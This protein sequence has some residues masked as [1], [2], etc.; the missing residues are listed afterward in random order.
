MLPLCPHDT[1]TRQG[2]WRKQKRLLWPGISIIW[3][4]TLLY[5]QQPLTVSFSYFLSYLLR[6]L[7]W[8]PLGP[9]DTVPPEFRTHPKA[10]YSTCCLHAHMVASTFR[11]WR[12]LTCNW[13]RPRS[14]ITCNWTLWHRR[15]PRHQGM[16]TNM[17]FG[18]YTIKLMVSL[19]QV[20]RRKG[21]TWQM[22]TLKNSWVLVFFTLS[23]WV[24]V[25]K[26]ACTIL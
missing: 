17:T 5:W 9:H 20:S 14:C 19:K 18:S 26:K 22:K 23:F 3:Y 13:L 11:F 21:G 10:A 24:N 6:G 15:P 16:V 12:Y 25:Q 2:P 7:S 4:V 1:V 8:C